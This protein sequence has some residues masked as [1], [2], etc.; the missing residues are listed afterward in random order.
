M[1][2]G[3]SPRW[4]RQARVQ[5]RG[6]FTDVARPSRRCASRAPSHGTC[7]FHALGR[8]VTQGSRPPRRAFGGPRP[9]TARPA[10]R[11]DDRLH[12]RRLHSLPYIGRARVGQPSL[13]AVIKPDAMRTR[14][15]AERRTY[16]G[17]CRRCRIAIRR[18]G[19]LAAARAARRS[20]DHEPPAAREV[21]G[22]MA[23]TSPR[24]VRRRAEVAGVT[25]RAVNRRRLRGRS[26]PRW[27]SIAPSGARS[28]RRDPRGRSAR[29][30]ARQTDHRRSA[31]GY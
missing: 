19:D 21:P 3:G 24:L 17:R 11:A 1:R 30:S 13:L 22:R 31:R 9:T 14:A 12:A 25:R 10:A 2:R 6:Y 18:R 16:P 29:S 20:L 7:W 28:A 8:R 4:T 15:G 5:R 26:A 23:E 27:G